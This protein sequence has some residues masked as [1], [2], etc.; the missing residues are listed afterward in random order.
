MTPWTCA[1]PGSFAWRTCTERWPKIVDALRADV[2]GADAPLAALRDEIR[3]GTVRLLRDPVLGAPVLCDVDEAPRWAAVT[4]WVGGPW[5]ALPWYLG[6]S[7]LYARVREAVGYG[8]TR[9]DPFLPIK[10]REERTV[11]NSPHAA[12]DDDDRGSA[13]D[14]ALWRA[15]WGNRADLSLPSARDHT[16]T[17]ENDLVVDDR[18]AA[19]AL[20]EGARSV[21]IVLDNA[22][23]ELAR[24]L[25]LAAVLERQGRRVTLFA[26][27]VPF[28][29]SDA[30]PADVAR[31]RAR[32][33][34]DLDAAVIADP[35]FTGPDFLTT[36]ALPSPL[37]DQ[38]AACDV[39]VVKG[40]CNYRRLVGDGPP[41]D[42]AFHDVVSFPAP[43][44]ALRT[45]KAEV[46]VGAD[47]VRV[48]SAAARDPDW[49][50]SG[51]FGLVQVRR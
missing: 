12:A 10:L 45:L 18:D 15:L 37:R 24:D 51:R 30:L 31:T 6:E 7:F 39:V 34:L 3:S 50:V 2:P 33:A 41:S 21:G 8:A 35:F 13:L 16:G 11:A 32:L 29:V 19:R 38:L 42:A 44:I 40:D 23:L 4:A 1:Q 28:F 17:D 48:A 14:A 36:A 9:A 43:L 22:G 25:E 27:D 20:L 47:P 46:L 5:T 49:L 26:K